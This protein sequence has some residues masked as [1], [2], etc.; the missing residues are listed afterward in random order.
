MNQRE[1]ILNRVFIDLQKISVPYGYT[2]TIKNFYKKY[3]SIGELNAD[4][5][6]AIWIGIENET[7][8][9]SDSGRN[10]YSNTL[11]LLVV[12]YL[13]ISNSENSLTDLAETIIRD[14]TDCLHQ[15]KVESSTLHTIT[16]VQSWN[17]KEIEPYLDDKNNKGIIVLQLEV[18]YIENEQSNTIDV[19]LP[20]TPT[21]SA[22]SN[23]GTVTTLYP[24]LDWTATNNT[25]NYQV[26][27]ATDSNFS[28]L[29]V[30][31]RFL[32]DASFTIPADK[33]LTN[34]STYYWRVRAYNNGGYGQWSSSQNFTTNSSS[35]TPIN[36]NQVPNATAWW[37]TYSSSGII[38]S[39]GI[40]ALLDQISGTYRLAQ[41][42]AGNRPQLVANVSGSISAAY[43][44]GTATGANS[45]WLSRNDAPKTFALT[46]GMSGTWLL[47][48]M[49]PSSLSA[50]YDNNGT[51]IVP[52]ARSNASFGSNYS[53]GRYGINASE[54]CNLI[55]YPDYFT[56]STA[57]CVLP[58]DR[59][60]QL[61]ATY[62]G[63]K[64]TIWKDGDLQTELSKVLG[65]QI[66]NETGTNLVI[67]SFY[68]QSNQ[69]PWQGYI[70]EI[71]F[72]SACLTSGT[73]AQ[74]YE[75]HKQRFN[76]N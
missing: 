61:L 13:Q 46:S 30:N 19:S 69:A 41:G 47:V 2:N 26:Q 32:D 14:I 76:I 60:F 75:G 43:W 25:L 15:Y 27:L 24:Q 1:A 44:A 68:A 31:Q 55:K 28:T 36:W 12:A 20:D 37:N 71:G 74:L 65:T 63:N 52:I 51:S 33:A 35:I 57:P 34:G 49:I 64:V 5:L 38:N 17:I 6:P 7:R 58:F 59:V 3:K 67:G 23:G 45:A 66:T 18:K 9:N 54:G 48:G 22:P 10:W 16:G 62:D 56:H 70:T 42:T 39:S 50:K 11:N 8:E 73:I 4:D 72:A 21:L 53:W 40:S 29:V